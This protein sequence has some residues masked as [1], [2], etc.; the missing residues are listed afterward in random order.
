M[1]RE[2]LIYACIILSLVGIAAGRLPFLRM[3]RASIAIG[4]ASI[5]IALGAISLEDSFEAVDPGTLLLLL[6]MML[7]VANLRL[8][9]FFTAAGAK[10]LSIARTPRVLL[11]LVVLAS[12]FLSAL[13]LNDT[14]CLML[15]PLVSVLALESERDPLPYLIAV[16]TAANIGSCATIIGNPQNILIGASSGISFGRFLLRL[17]PISLLSLS[18][19][20][21]AVL[22]AF[23]KEF[24]RG[25]TLKVGQ[26]S[27]KATDPLL[28]AKSLAAAA[29]ML[30][31]LFAGVAPP[32]AA[33][34][35]A[36]I[37]LFTR[38]LSPEKVFA[39]VDFSLLVFFTGL[40]II[41]KAIALSPA[42][43]SLMD[44]VRP[45]IASPGGFSLGIFSAITALLSN[46]VSNVP[47]V[48]LLRPLASLFADREK[49]WLILAMASTYAG[50]LTLLGSVA[51]LIVAEGAKRDGIHVGFGSYL[52]VGFPVTLASIAIGTFFL[53]AT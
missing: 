9:G 2:T 19:V 14:I 6:A 39:E 52:R 15:T 21:L 42:F 36:A 27:A 24:R 11:F 51:N 40:F 44:L 46:L 48:M 17:G 47:T 29:L 5:L 1:I 49:A 43:S 28:I 41:T 20:Y 33:L 50:N 25:S 53:L 34:V 31:L 45:L 18:L 32:L 38:R 8:A 26:A 3:N 7:L 13:F 4:F 30:G 16:A 10:I 12:G 35:A 37:L 22:L 23:P